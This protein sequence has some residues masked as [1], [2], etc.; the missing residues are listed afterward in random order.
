MKLLSQIFPI[1]TEEAIPLGLTEV[2]LKVCKTL[3]MKAHLTR[4]LYPHPAE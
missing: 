3:S 1:M 2:R 4:V